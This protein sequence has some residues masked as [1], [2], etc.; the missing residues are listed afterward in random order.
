MALANL[1]IT[2]FYFIDWI[3]F[4]WKNQRQYW[5]SWSFSRFVRDGVGVFAS[6][7]SSRLLMSF[8]TKISHRCE[9]EHFLTFLNLPHKKSWEREIRS[10][11]IVCFLLNC[12]RK[13]FFCFWSFGCMSER[14]RALKCN[15]NKVRPPEFCEQQILCEGNLTH[16]ACK[17]GN[18]S[19]EISISRN[20]IIHVSSK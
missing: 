16:G 2:I 20:Y 4:G 12:M 13:H 5:L 19:L 18:L 11:T 6:S 15:K 17:K 9:Q 8:M 10:D 14:E 7:F 3:Y 1:L